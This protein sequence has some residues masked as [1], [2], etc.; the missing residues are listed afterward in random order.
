VFRQKEVTNARSEMKRATQ[1]YLFG[2]F[3]AKYGF[4]FSGIDES[5]QAQDEF[6]HVDEPLAS[7]F[8]IG[9]QQ[10]HARQ[11]VVELGRSITFLDLG[12]SRPQALFY[13][14]NLTCEHVMIVNNAEPIRFAEVST[15]HNISLVSFVQC[16]Q[17]RIAV[18]QINNVLPGMAGN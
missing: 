1:H 5:T 12:M 16:G 17:N 2:I 14:R 13:A 8:D 15:T 10:G 4:Q 18:G 3:V 7:Q 11:S 9:V 6:L